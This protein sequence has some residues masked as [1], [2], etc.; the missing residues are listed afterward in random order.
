MLVGPTDAISAAFVTLTD[1]GT[2]SLDLSTGINFSLTLG[3]NR[4]LANPTN[5]KAGQSGVI[6]VTNP[7]TYTLSFNSSYKFAGGA[8]PTITTSGTTVLSYYVVNASY[9][10]VVAILGVA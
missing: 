10:V 8:A 2:I 7:S 3:G 4:T 5:T 6:V 1:A 9:I